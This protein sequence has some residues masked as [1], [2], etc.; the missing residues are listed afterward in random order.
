MNHLIK[1]FYED[2]SAGNREGAESAIEGIKALQAPDSLINSLAF[3]LEI[4]L[5][6][7]TPAEL[8]QQLDSYHNCK[9]A[10]GV[11]ETAP[12]TRIELGP[13]VSI[14]IVSFNSSQDLRI[15]LPT[16]TAQSYR[17]YEVIVVENGEED[18]E[19]LLAAHL[20]T[21]TYVKADTNIGFAAANNMAASHSNG[22]YL[23]LLNPDTKLDKD[24]IKE[25]LR[26]ISHESS[27][28]LAACPKIYFFREFVRVLLNRI[29]D[30]CH[31]DLG[32][33]MQDLGYTK[34]FI[35]QGLLSSCGGFVQPDEDGCIAIDIPTPEDHES[36]M[37]SIIPRRVGEFVT[38]PP[39][40]MVEIFIGDTREPANIIPIGS[41]FRISST[42][43]IRSISRRLI[44]NASS[45]MHAD[46]MP[47]D[48]GFADEDHSRY[49]R[50]THVDAFC[51]CCV[52]L[53][54]M[55]WVARRIF[56]ADFFAYFED[57]ELSHWLKLH[58]Y[59]ILYCPAS[60]VYHRHS[61][62]T[63]EKSPNWH[64]LVGRSRVLYQWM[65]GKI[66]DAGYAQ[67]LIRQLRTKSVSHNLLS[68][69][70]S[71]YPVNTLAKGSR[72]QKRPVTTVAIY[73]S[74]WTTFG[75]GEKHA[76]DIASMISGWKDHEV[77][78]LS[79]RDFDVEDL[80]IY[81][82]IDLSRCVP[83]RL[84]E[85]SSLVTAFFDIF[86]NSTYCSQLHSRAKMNF[87]IVSFPTRTMPRPLLETCTFLHNSQFTMRWA[88]KYWGQH[89]SVVVHP[90]LGCVPPE[91]QHHT[92]R[93]Q[94]VSIGRYN[95]RGHCKNHHLLIEAF[96]IAKR[97][98]LLSSEW[99]YVIAGSLDTKVE[100]SVA[101]YEQCKNLVEDDSVALLSNVRRDEIEE[102]YGDGFAYL[103]G[104]GMTVDEDKEPEL[105]EHFGIAVFDAIL[106]GC[107]P[108]VHNSGGARDILEYAVRGM[109]YE[110][111][112]GLVNQLAT[113][114]ALYAESIGS[115]TNPHQHDHQ[116]LAERSIRHNQD[117][118]TSALT[119]ASGVS[120][121]SYLPSSL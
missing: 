30:D 36:I 2:L 33:A 96:Y 77:Y 24:T 46:G 49:S 54:R 7:D 20:D 62:T 71:L 10:R 94:I 116:S 48:Q 17:N 39:R 26:G 28:A 101:H 19:P 41:S 108:I 11:R 45:G 95:L 97:R 47:Y 85:V 34:M 87:Y 58:G 104:T 52:L 90:V 25:L 13:L 93:R 21:Y 37:L 105:C 74:F 88:E 92:K 121:Q 119:K 69:V 31:L 76:L 73:N 113:L 67:E 65:T 106:H 38:S 61:E 80:S 15:L 60:I 91:R 53:H 43:K 103:H 78:L 6:S 56:L 82:G 27:H 22:E 12:C 110:D 8:T 70:T 83:M 102:L 109:T 40:G 44:N 72:S 35:R 4:S 63:Q 99:T 84:D 32:L 51:G 112:D 100:S 66:T 75:G 1:R 18:N 59:Q 14:L 86:I 55:V 9:I 89:R 29:P 117:V 23:L 57:S 16:I 111:L 120:P 50:L 118:F 3:A 81:F 68:Q 98:G 107:I 64:Y 79:D 42:D 5:R 114:D 115:E